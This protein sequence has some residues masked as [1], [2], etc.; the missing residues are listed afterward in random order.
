MSGWKREEDKLGEREGEGF[1]SSITLRIL[2]S[3]T[4]YGHT[5]L[6]QHCPLA[7]QV[8]KN[9]PIIILR[10]IM[11]FCNIGKQYFKLNC[12]IKK[13]IT[14]WMFCENS[15][16]RAIETWS[17]N[18]QLLF[19]YI[20]IYIYLFIHLFIYILYFILFIDMYIFKLYCHEC[21]AIYKINIFRAFIRHQVQHQLLNEMLWFLEFI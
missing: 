13:I 16:F 12:F 9:K 20:Y 15:F 7:A 1:C 8:I 4:E 11:N 5:N 19:L 10:W 2:F 17:Y 6:E 3:M 18:Y 21:A 14:L